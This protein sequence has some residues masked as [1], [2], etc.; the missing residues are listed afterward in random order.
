MV[1]VVQPVLVRLARLSEYCPVHTAF[2]HCRVFEQVSF[3]R[4]CP[5]HISI[6]RFE[7]PLLP[8]VTETTMATSVTE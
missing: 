1:F 2:T 3:P 4:L 8:K 6:T 5:W 7:H